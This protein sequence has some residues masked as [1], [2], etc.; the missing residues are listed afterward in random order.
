MLE[1]LAEDPE[2]TKKYEE[3]TAM[4]GRPPLTPNHFSINTVRGI[5]MH[6]ILAYARW[7]R[8]NLIS[9]EG[10]DADSGRWR[11]RGF[12]DAPEVQAM[13]VRRLDPMIDPTRTVRSVYG[14]QLPSL[15]FLD[16]RWV[17]AI[18]PEIFPTDE[19]HAY[20]HD[21]AWDAYVVHPRPFGSVFQLLREEYARAVE[22]LEGRSPVDPAKRKRPDPEEALGEQLMILYWRGTLHFEEPDQ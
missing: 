19:D 13:L 11:W 7:V 16:R 5:A 9:E 4:R 1:R 8:L 3:E 15:A 6:A 20:L 21:A 22:R 18:L 12:V 14:S 10:G 17:E 2:P